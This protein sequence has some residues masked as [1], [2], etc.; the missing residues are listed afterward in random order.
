MP[1][2]NSHASGL[3][4]L[5]AWLAAPRVHPPLLAPPVPMLVSA[6]APADAGFGLL[7]CTPT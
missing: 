5:Q 2:Q 3:Q 7:R 1:E 6:E 4:Q